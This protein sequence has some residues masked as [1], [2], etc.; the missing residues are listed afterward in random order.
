MD[1]LDSAYPGRQA[2]ASQT[3]RVNPNQSATLHF[4][5][6]LTGW[7]SEV[8][9]RVSTKCPEGNS[10][11]SITL[12]LRA[13]ALPHNPSFQANKLAS[14]FVFD[15]KRCQLSIR[16]ITGLDMSGPVFAIEIGAVNSTI[17]N[18][19]HEGLVGIEPTCSAH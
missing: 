9:G 17:H 16:E 13:I 4:I 18:F 7:E 19:I 1:F 15:E 2:S 3:D 12:F 8:L 10:I 6:P 14:L 11:P 5:S